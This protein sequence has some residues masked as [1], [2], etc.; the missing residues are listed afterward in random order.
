M[1]K[2]RFR[3][4]F[5]GG[6]FPVGSGHC[7]RQAIY[8]LMNLPDTEPAHPKLAAT[9]GAGKGV[10]QQITYRWG[11]AG[12]TLGGSVPLEEGGPEEQLRLVDSR[13]WLSTAIDSVLDLRPDWPAVV[14]VDIKSKAEKV[15]EE[16]RLGA[17]DYDPVH[18]AQVVCYCY[19]ARLYHEE[20]GWAAMG[21]KPAEGGF[22]YYVS[23]DN[24]AN[25]REFWIEYRE[26]DVN[27]ALLML[28]EWKDSFL[29]NRLPER[30]KAW[31]WTEHPCKWCDVKKLCKADVKDDVENIRESGVI[32]YAKGVDPKYDFEEIRAKVLKRWE[33]QT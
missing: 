13:Y 32:D 27:D 19:I 5:W 10:E 3:S 8:R 26:S 21:L 22:I 31:R 28:Q 24:P 30:P 18:A 11:R 7:G 4:S 15:I 33:E 14:P 17:T 6:S 1:N 16:M 23:R 2:G 9:A 12:L 29:E 20:M 25:A